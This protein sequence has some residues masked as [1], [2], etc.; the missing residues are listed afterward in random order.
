MVINYEVEATQNKFA[1]SLIKWKPLASRRI[2]PGQRAGGDRGN[3][4]QP[5]PGARQVHLPAGL[6]G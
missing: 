4:R 6:I 1:E 2:H 3:R 5:H